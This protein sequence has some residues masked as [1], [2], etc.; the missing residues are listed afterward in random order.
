MNSWLREH[1]PVP[2]GFP[3]SRRALIGAGLACSAL[4]FGKPFLSAANES[5]RSISSPAAHLWWLPSATLLRPARPAAPSE[6][7]AEELLA[8][9]RERTAA[10]AEVVKRWDRQPAI[11]PWTDMALEMIK[12]AKPSPARVGR[13]LAL[14]HVAMADTMTAVA[15]AQWVWHR[16]APSVSIAGLTSLAG[17]DDAGWSYPSEH[18]AIAGAAAVVLS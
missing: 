10:T 12:A 9:Q 11:L 7:E 14:L 2:P 8:M 13:A 4:T 17:D 6:A 1:R 5:S 18:A 15:D 3:L 16:P